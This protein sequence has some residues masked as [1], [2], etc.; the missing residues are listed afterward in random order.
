MS[1][2]KQGKGTKRKAGSEG[3]DEKKKKAK[4]P[5]VEEKKEVKVPRPADGKMVFK[6][7]PGKNGHLLEAS[8]FP[9]EHTGFSKFKYQAHEQ[10]YYPSFDN[11]WHLGQIAYPN[12]T[13]EALESPAV[14]TRWWIVQGAADDLRL[15]K[16]DGQNWGYCNFAG[17]MLI[18][19]RFVA[20]DNE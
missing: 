1:S 13:E 16:K 4:V 12:W 10:V 11:L 9:K 19:A 18:P 15:P 8:T 6:L 14:A 5:R 17:F 20:F 3:K 7:L 2:S